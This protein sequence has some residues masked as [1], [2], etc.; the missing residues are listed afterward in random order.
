MLAFAGG[1]TG[2]YILDNVSV[3]K[4]SYAEVCRGNVFEN[5]GFETT[6]ASPWAFYGNPPREIM[7]D[8]STGNTY[9]RIYGRNAWNAWTRGVF[10]GIQTKCIIPGEEWKVKFK[11]RLVDSNGNGIDCVPAENNRNCPMV[12][13]QTTFAPAAATWNDLYDPHMV[14]NKDGW[15]TFETYF[16]TTP[17]TAG[18]GLTSF[19][20]LFGGGPQGSELIV[21]D[22][23]FEHAAV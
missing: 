22:L 15:S 7:T 18:P 17:D 21:D 11:T 20:V 23:V 6:F 10:Q 2:T 12:R 16:I 13:I 8:S 19:L 4:R 14:W 3:R 1:N 5:P 9:L